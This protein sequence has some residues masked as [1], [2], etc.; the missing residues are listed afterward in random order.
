MILAKLAGSTVYYFHQDY[1]ANTR[2]VT[3]GTT[4]TFTSNYQPFGTQYGATGTDPIYKYTG[5][6]QDNST[7]LYFYGARY[8][9]KSIGAFITRDPAKEQLQDPQT[10]CPYPYARNNPESL[11]DP[12]GA[13][14]SKLW[15]AG[16][17]VAVPAA[18]FGI[19]YLQW[20]VPWAWNNLVVYFLFSLLP[21]TLWY[22]SVQDWWG[23]FWNV[24]VRAAWQVIWTLGKYLGWLGWMGFI[25]R[26]GS[27]WWWVP[28]AGTLAWFSI[29]LAWQYFNPPYQYQFCPW[30]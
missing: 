29:Q 25:G 13:C 26:V 17:L 8:Y 3:T 7:G 11:T 20:T 1:L 27:G 22:I 2:L 24:I 16:Q 10:R 28:L 12:S 21:P 6:P 18:L 4:T 23:L 14:V 30:W 5:K 15:L 19:Y 9:D